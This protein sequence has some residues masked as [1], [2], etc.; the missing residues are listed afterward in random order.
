M[1]DKSRMNYSRLRSWSLR[2]STAIIDQG[3][4]SGSNFLLNVLLA[5]WLTPTDYGAFAVT[6]TVFLFLSGFH[7]ALLLEPMSV[8]GPGSYS[9]QMEAYLDAQIRLNFVLTLA[10]S[11]LMTLVGMI[12]SIIHKGD[13]TL[14]RALVGGSLALPFILFL[15][16]IRRIFYV[17][18]R[19]A[20]AMFSSGL[21]M[22]FLGAGV[23]EMHLWGIGSSFNAFL[24]MGVASFL[25]GFLVGNKLLIRRR[26]ASLPWSEIIHAHWNFGRWVT[27]AAIL[28]VGLGQSQTLILAGMLSLDAAGA[29]RAMQNFTLPMTQAVT[30]IA[31]LGLPVLA[32]DYG[33]RDLLSLRRKGL[34]ITVVLTG[35]AVTYEVLIGVFGV[36]LEQLVYGGKYT[37]YTWLIPLL[38]LVPIFSALS[39]G[40]TLTLRAVQKP[41]IYLVGGIIAA[42]IGL[43]SA[44]VLIRAVGIMGAAISQVLVYSLGFVA[45][46]Y[47]YIRWFPEI[48]VI[49][50]VEHD[51]LDKL[52]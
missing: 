25:S 45:N 4:Y 16:T 28:S 19:P 13:P 51:G 46:L 48:K 26:N 20:S 29:F 23:W 14:W 8:L 21:Y 41:Q 22:L 52:S 12:L 3:L 11:I 7:N 39:A 27:V 40:L 43:P 15:W 44:L 36:P 17:V 42:V 32:Y 30:A 50:S 1:I 35:I 10:L 37:A 5:R 33:Q 49:V 34:F 24:W 2:G 38:G 31:T 47:F 6:F 9:H 18:K